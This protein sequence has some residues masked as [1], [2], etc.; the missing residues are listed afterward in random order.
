[1]GDF[2][3]LAPGWHNAM[4]YPGG[5]DLNAKHIEMMERPADPIVGPSCAA[6]Q[7]LA[8]AIES[9]GSLD[10]QAIRDAIA[11]TDMDTMIG[12]V[13]FRDDGTGVVV[14]PFLQYQEGT[15]AGMATRVR[16][17][18]PCHPGSAL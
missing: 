10:R 11:A 17:R 14:A 15:A 6:I 9:A 12:P 8:G 7:I 3:V 13:T 4:A 18:R 2:V 1:V 16:H 5:A